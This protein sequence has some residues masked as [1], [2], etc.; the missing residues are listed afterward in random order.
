MNRLF[1]KLSKIE[2]GTIPPPE[3]FEGGGGDTSPPVP[4]GIAA[5]GVHAHNLLHPPPPD[6][7]SGSASD[8]HGP[9]R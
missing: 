7:N 3:K 2:G 1:F 8:I 6:E 9:Y 5:Y 4:P